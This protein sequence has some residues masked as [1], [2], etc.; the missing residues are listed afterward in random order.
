MEQHPFES[1]LSEEGSP[2]TST[3]APSTEIKRIGW[4]D[5]HMP[6]IVDPLDPPH[7]ETSLTETRHY[8]H[9]GWTPAKMRVFHERFAES[10]VLRDAC[11]AVGMSARSAYNLRDRDPLVAAGWEAAALKR[12]TR[13]ADESYSRSV[14]GVM[15][16]IYKDGVIVAE[17]H[18]Y[19]NRLTMSVLARLDARIDRAEERGDPSLN[20]VARWDEYLDALGEGRREDGMALLAP[21]VSSPEPAAAADLQTHARDRELHEL[22]QQ[23]GLENS[24]PHD[25]WEEADGWWTNYP[26]PDGFDGDEEGCY[27]ECGYQ[28]TLSPAEQAAI[29]AEGDSARAR[30]EAQRD[31]WFGFAADDPDADRDDDGD[32]EP[33]PADS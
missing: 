12:R 16:R 26:P 32:A 28:R 4:I 5:G 10:G 30:A 19:D 23:E 18:R 6:D 20:L 14:N 9:D 8:R 24:D 17:R 22:R 29:D 31:A 1:P 27:G 15:E 7:P 13:L 21:P 11:E 33:D 3:S 25:V 2:D